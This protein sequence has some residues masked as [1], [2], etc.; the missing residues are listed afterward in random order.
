MPLDQVDVD[1]MKNKDE[2]EMSFLDHLEALR[3]HLVR[4]IVAIFVIAIVSFIFSDL[5]IETLL[6]GPKEKWFPTYKF[7]C[8]ISEDLCLSLIHISEPTRPY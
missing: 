1:K 4:S 5:V 8:S 6:Y 2:A 7:I 3:W